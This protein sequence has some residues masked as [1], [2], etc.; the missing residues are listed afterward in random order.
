[1][2]DTLVHVRSV[3]AHLTTPVDA[4][5]LLQAHRKPMQL[6]NLQ[7]VLGTFHML[8]KLGP[9]LL[10]RTTVCISPELQVMTCPALAF[11]HP[12]TNQILPRSIL[13]LFPLGSI[14]AIAIG[15]AIGAVVLL[16]VAIMIKKY[17]KRPAKPI[18]PDLAL[19]WDDADTK[20]QMRLKPAVWQNINLIIFNSAASP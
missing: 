15:A 19:D 1:M 13:K 8:M 3:L 10:A 12:E 5:S 17:R 16:V 18:K 4:A 2:L 14:N 11:S 9:L 7:R 6:L 20:M